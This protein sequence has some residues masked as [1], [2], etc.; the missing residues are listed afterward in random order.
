MDLELLGDIIGDENDI[1]HVDE[2][3]SPE[4]ILTL[5]TPPN[6]YCPRASAWQ[7]RIPV[8]DS[9][10]QHHHCVFAKNRVSSTNTCEVLAALTCLE[11]L[12]PI[13]VEVAL[14]HYD[15]LQNSE[16]VTPR[17]GQAPSF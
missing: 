10:F 12:P 13:F 17:P 8:Q 5:A 2:L 7:S 15:A 16:R 14:K 6:R 3:I 11:K 9:P 1:L 4:I